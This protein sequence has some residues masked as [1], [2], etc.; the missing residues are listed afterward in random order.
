VALARTA[1]AGDADAADLARAQQALAQSIGTINHQTN[2]AK[3]AST[4]PRWRKRAAAAIA[5]AQSHLAGIPQ[6]LADVLAADAARL[7][8]DSRAADAKR[9]A[10]EAPPDARD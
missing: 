5:A 8:A 6:Q 1:R 3:D 9:A 4:D 7:Q 2:I 10:A